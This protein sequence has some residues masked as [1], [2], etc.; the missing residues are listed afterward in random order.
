MFLLIYFKILNLI[1]ISHSKSVPD[2][3]QNNNRIST[4]PRAL[5]PAAAKSN[6]KPAF[7]VGSSSS[8]ES[9]EEQEPEKEKA[10]QREKYAGGCECFFKIDIYS[11]FFS[12]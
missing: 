1:K 8:S 11:R 10:R 2:V 12:F 4:P 3:K 9:E 7:N 6:T 5:I